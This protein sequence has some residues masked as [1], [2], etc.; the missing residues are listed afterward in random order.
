MVRIF[1]AIILV[2]I[3]QTFLPAQ[4][5]FMLAYNAVTDEYAVSMMPERTWQSPFNKTAAGQ[6]TLKATTGQ[7]FVKEVISHLEDTEWTVS[8]RVDGPM[9]SPKY[10]Y[11]F[12][13][14]RTPGLAE[15]PYQAF[16]PTKLF[17]FKLESNCAKEVMLV[18]NYEDE[19]LPP[20]S[21]RINIGNSLGVLGARGEAYIGNVSDLP[22]FCP[23]AAASTTD[24][25]EVS[26]TE[27]VRETKVITESSPLATL[28]KEPTLFPNPTVDEV[29]ISLHWIGSNGKKE[30][31]V[32]SA[33]GQLARTFT[34]DI[35]TGDNSFNLN[36]KDLE[37]GIYNFILVDDNTAIDIGKIIKV[38]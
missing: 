17:T 34:T 7:F 32:Y 27:S 6:V 4:V 18:S 13:R 20:N 9:E 31:L 1:K 16:K 8:G 38:N 23:Y 15:L 29:N 35:Q 3:S 5:K 14:L 25:R 22:I 30:V 24:E 33:S 11:I 10:D 2:I 19:F 26:E 28:S 21:K 37:N 12:F 36:I